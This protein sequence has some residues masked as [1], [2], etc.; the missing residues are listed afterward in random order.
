MRI[1]VLWDIMLFIA[2]NVPQDHNYQR[3]EMSDSKA[4]RS[5]AL[6]GSYVIYRDQAFGET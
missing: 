2:V 6:G 3:K 5:R 4:K 1:L